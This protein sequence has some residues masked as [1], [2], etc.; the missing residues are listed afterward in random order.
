[1]NRVNLIAL[2]LLFTASVLAQDL[3]TVDAVAEAR[4]QKSLQE[5]A[6]LR[7]KIR[8]EQIPLVSRLNNLEGE[9]KIKRRDAERLQSARDSKD[10]ELVALRQRIEAQQREMDFITRT[11]LP[12]FLSSFDAS[13]NSGERGGVGEKMRQL[14][15][16]LEDP[17]ASDADKLNGRLEMLETS[18]TYAGKLIGGHSYQGK[19]L[20]SGGELKP[21]SFVQIGPLLYFTGDESSGIIQETQS[22]MPKVADMDESQASSIRQVAQ[23]GTGNIPVDTTLGD[24]WALETTKDTPIEH[25]RKGGIWVYPILGFAL[26]ATLTALCKLVQIFRI[27]QPES[28]TVNKIVKALREND[29]QKALSI[30]N[31]QPNPAREMLVS[32][33]E[34]ANESTELVEEVMYECM[35]TTQPRLERFLNIIA[36]TAATAPLLGLLGTVTGIIKTFKLMSIHGAGD[37]KPLI[38]GISEAL[39]TTELGLVLAIPALVLHALLSRKVAGIMA[40]IEKLSIAFLNAL[41]RK[42]A[43]ELKT[44]SSET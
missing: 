6:T 15:L 10:V 39:I 31:A 13:L 28:K 37:P 30:A 35:L 23:T 26:I 38:S 18:L 27:R 20:G 12:E 33:V 24:A 34:N 19:A 21:G 22:L 41:N 3:A 17:N 25:L 14:N 8:T 2:N 5:L 16:F 36:L 4:V 9:V 1:M 43:I 42:D 29:R 11:L 7:E 44:A 32:A 40:H